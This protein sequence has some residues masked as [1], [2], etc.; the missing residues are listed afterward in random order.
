MP[1]P[2]GTVYGSALAISG[3][4]CYNKQNQQFPAPYIRRREK[5]VPAADG[6]PNDA[7]KE[8]LRHGTA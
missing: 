7:G 6:L 4:V 5:A 3:G 1:E 8:G 2:T